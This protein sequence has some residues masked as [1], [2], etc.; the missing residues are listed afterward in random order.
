M[1]RYYWKTQCC[2]PTPNMRMLFLIDRERFHQDDGIVYQ[3]LQ[4]ENDGWI[5]S[6]SCN[7]QLLL[8]N[9]YTLLGLGAAD[10]KELACFWSEHCYP[11]K[12]DL[13]ERVLYDERGFPLVEYTN[14]DAYLAATGAMD[15]DDLPDDY[16]CR[17]WCV[18]FYHVNKEWVK[19]FLHIH[20]GLEWRESLVLTRVQARG[21]QAVISDG[22]E[23][24]Q[25]QIVK[26]KTGELN[27]E[28]VART[29]AFQVDTTDIDQLDWWKNPCA[30]TPISYYR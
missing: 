22:A 25:G 10:P 5:M 7:E 8:M 1:Y 4:V 21:E 19:L 9:I 15:I 16:E 17:D 23:P 28:Q 13:H 18:Q 14:A 30:P 12:P 26:V 2:V 6:L 11:G 29:L 27:F 3:L 24:S 20:C